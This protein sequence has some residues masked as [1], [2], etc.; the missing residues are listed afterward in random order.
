MYR[1]WT[2]VICVLLMVLLA[3]GSVFF[4]TAG[5]PWLAERLAR[6]AETANPGWSARLYRWSLA[7][8]PYDAPV[9]LALAQVY[10]DSGYPLKAED[11]L[12][13]GVDHYAVGPTL[14]LALA[15]MYVDTG[16]L[17]EACALLDSAPSGYLSKRLSSLR[18]ENAAA[19]PSGTYAQGL[20]FM[21]EGGEGVAW[22]QVNNSP[23]TM[24]GTP[25]AL[26]EGHYTLRVLTLDEG[27]IPSPINEY[28][29]RVEK[30]H[31]ASVF[32][33]AVTCPFCGESW[34][35]WRN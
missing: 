17:D 32:W 1:T 30:L 26:P 22:Y 28:R 5:R 15:S 8:N 33:Q 4:A 10:M 35:E 16:R 18:P 20:D 31:P 34:P 11:L 14:Y 24:Y 23:W 19:P 25:L 3:A 7:V 9:R 13:E 27:S 2:A 29:Y 12:R 21:L 6:K